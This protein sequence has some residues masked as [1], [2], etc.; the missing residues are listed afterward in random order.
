MKL[1]K[2]K[3]SETNLN[4]IT[5]NKLFRDKVISKTLLLLQ[6]SRIR[7]FRLEN[8]FKTLLQRCRTVRFYVTL[9]VFGRG[10]LDG[11]EYGASLRAPWR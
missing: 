3:A 2:L 1:S 7:T 6:N 5:S 8:L 11:Q 4:K 10:N 9:I